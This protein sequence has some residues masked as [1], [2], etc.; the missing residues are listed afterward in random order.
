MAIAWLKDLFKGRQT[1]PDGHGHTPNGHTSAA[2]ANQSSEAV[3]PANESDMERT[4]YWAGY[5]H[6]SH[7]EQLREW[8][9]G[10]D[11][12]LAGWGS[13]GQV[14]LKRLLAQNGQ[15]V[16]SVTVS[17]SALY[18]VFMG[19]GAG[20]IA[21]YARRVAGRN[22]P[23]Q[24]ETHRQLIEALSVIYGP[25]TAKRALPLIQE[26]ISTNGQQSRY[27][28]PPFVLG[29]DPITGLDLGLSPDDL[30]HSLSL[31]G[32]SG[33]GKSS[34]MVRLAVY[35]MERR[36]SLIVIDPHGT[37]ARDIIAAIPQ[38]RMDA[39]DVLDLMDCGN[40]PMGLNIFACDDPGDPT[41]VAKA[42]SAVFHIF[43]KTWLM[44]VQTPLLAQVVRHI[45]YTFIEAGLTLG[46]VGLFLFDDTFRQKITAGISNGHTRLFW[47]QF[48]KKSPRDRTEYTNST[49]NKLDALLTQPILANIL[50][51]KHSTIDLDR[52]TKEGRILILLLNQQFEEAS[53]LVGNIV[54][55]KLLLNA[56]ARAERPDENH[57]PVALLVDEWQL[58]CSSSSDFARFVHESRKAYYMPCY[59][60]QSLSQLDE[61]N[62]GAALSSG[63]I[64]ALRINGDDARIVSRGLDATPQPF[65]VGV[66]PQRAP[67][68]DVIGHLVRRGH[69]DDRVTRFAQTY[70]APLEKYASTPERQ[71]HVASHDSHSGV[72]VLHDLEIARGRKLLN[73]ALYT[74]QSERR[75]NIAIDPLALYVLVTAQGTTA[76][77]ALSRYIDTSAIQSF[78]DRK[79]RDSSSCA[80][81]AHFGRPGFLTDGSAA[82]FVAIQRRKRRW[83]AER[84]VA[85]LTELKYVLTVLSASPVMVDTGFMVPKYQLRTVSDQTNYIAN[86]LSQMP[87]FHA[88]VKTLHGECTIR[89]SPPRETMRAELVQERISYIKHRMLERGVIRPA[90]DVLEELRKRHELLRGEAN[91]APPTRSTTATRRPRRRPQRDD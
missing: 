27:T 55:T 91:D 21:F 53:R 51:Q 2:T 30:T 62:I 34:A 48:N 11:R 80:R 60:N 35:H 56:F 63:T 26:L 83:M 90:A 8:E 78:G 73:D 6:L 22:S 84:I 74:A 44:S 39:V 37:L 9:A 7:D 52:I 24:F 82:R 4:A 36:H 12:W 57:T 1:P 89:L 65:E 54:L 28:P 40:F 87:L 70:L 77:Y 68:A 64:A 88:R 46:E 72:L 14:F 45:C 79:L 86:T 42:A 61:E 31:L 75:G 81:M 69:V 23:S 3:S 85:M 50:C 18:S 67:V 47:E 66:E 71:R 59:A 33:S 38:D 49:S 19:E 29:T 17:A 32:L 43:E 25:E 16:D 13:D 20:D 15:P 5:A 58:F 76:E 41:E 10:M